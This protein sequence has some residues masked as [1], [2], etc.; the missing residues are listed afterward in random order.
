MPDQMYV[1]LSRITNLCAM[2]LYLCT[3][4]QSLQWKLTKQLK[5]STH[6]L[7]TIFG[8]IYQQ[9]Y[10]KK[11]YIVTSEYTTSKKTYNRYY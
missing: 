8:I 3:N 10:R 9:I 1:T 6:D 2:Y 11:I 7:T 4:T 5:K